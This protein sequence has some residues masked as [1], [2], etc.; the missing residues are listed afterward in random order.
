MSE[1]HTFDEG[2]V[3]DILKAHAEAHAETAKSLSADAAG[4][5]GGH[6]STM[7]LAECIAVVVNKDGKV[8]VKLPLGL[9]THCIPIPTP[10]PAGTAGEA[11]LKIK[12]KFGIPCGV[13]VTI[14]IAG[15]EVVK[16]SFGLC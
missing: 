11:C 10:F 3:N 9:G 13:E 6:S 7:A 4:M 8:C 14:T 2:K 15:K 16:K 5:F 1:V 12:T